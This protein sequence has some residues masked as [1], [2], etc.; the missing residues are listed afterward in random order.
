MIWQM[1]V[2]RKREGDSQGKGKN[3]TTHGHDEVSHGGGLESL[4]VKEKSRDKGRKEASSSHDGK[5]RLSC[6]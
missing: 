3:I 2:K 4:V 6:G 5:E 1:S